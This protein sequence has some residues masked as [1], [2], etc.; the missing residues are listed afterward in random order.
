M[1]H[2]TLPTHHTQHNM[3][4]HFFCRCHLCLVVPKS[5]VRL[6]RAVSCLALWSSSRFN[7]VMVTGFFRHWRTKTVALRPG[8]VGCWNIGMSWIRR[9]EDWKPVE[10]HC[11]TVFWATRAAG[12][13]SL[14]Q[15]DP[16][17]EFWSNSYKIQEPKKT[18]KNSKSTFSPPLFLALDQK[19]PRSHRPHAKGTSF[20]GLKWWASW[21]TISKPTWAGKKLWKNKWVG[22]KIPKLGFKVAVEFRPRWSY[23]DFVF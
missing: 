7:K 2:I 15:L 22:W 13:E 21:E 19:T 8:C 12:N 23:H 3:N 16:W 5:A 20:R 1:L 9:S 10:M 14:N 17:H 6:S 18:N 4:P 11:T